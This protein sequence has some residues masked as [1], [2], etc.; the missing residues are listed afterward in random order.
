M[1]RMIEVEVKKWHG[2][3]EN[4]GFGW[5]PISVNDALRLRDDTFR[6]PECHGKVRL[7]SAS[8]EAGMAAHGEHRQRN[9]GCSLGDCFD[10]EKRRHTSA[11][12]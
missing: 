7:H 10:G 8:T 6:C 9:R 1:A 4:R 5:H 11:L 2:A 3:A 12:E